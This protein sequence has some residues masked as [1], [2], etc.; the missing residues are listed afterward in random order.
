MNPIV[1]IIIATRNSAALLPTALESV[2]CQQFHDWECLII[3]GASTDATLDVIA[4]Y[5]AMDTRFRHI[6]EPDR[7]VYDAFNKGARLAQGEWLY[8]IG[9]DDR[10]LPTSFTSLL[11]QAG[12]TRA[13]V[14]S[15]CINVIKSDGACD[16]LPS[17]GWEGCHQA[18]LTRRSS[19]LKM[20]G[21]DLSYRISAD[22]DL[23]VRMRI[24]GMSIED[25]TTPPICDFTMGGMSQQLRNYGYILR[26]YFQIFGK[27]PSISHPHVKATYIVGRMLAAN[28]YHNLRRSLS[29]NRS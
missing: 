15:G 7:G 8:Y 16:L 4:R 17:K 2:R 12:D 18:K 25:Y 28:L 27:D 6:S 1:S 22:L 19:L 13:D 10:L 29:N 14:I 11:Q 23:Y 26:E 9:S 3:D 20:Q 21:Y 5:E 24:A